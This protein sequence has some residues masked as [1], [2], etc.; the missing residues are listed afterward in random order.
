MEI[1]Q[2]PQPR[3][4]EGFALAFFQLCFFAPLVWLGTKMRANPNI[5]QL[6]FLQYISILLPLRLVKVKSVTST[7]SSQNLWKLALYTTLFYLPLSSLRYFMLIGM[8]VI[9]K[10]A[11]FFP[12][13]IT[14]FFIIGLAL[15]TGIHF[16]LTRVGLR[17]LMKKSDVQIKSK[18]S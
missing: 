6:L 1:T 17:F 14:P 11:P 7:T 4:I 2:S 15:G 3:L 5:L 13:K 8:G 16:L 18:T 10:D 9:E 12:E